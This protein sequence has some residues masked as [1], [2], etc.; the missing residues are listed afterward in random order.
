VSGCV[1]WLRPLQVSTIV[2]HADGACMHVPLQ[3]QV[4]T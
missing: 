1:A 3:L 2:A 4:L